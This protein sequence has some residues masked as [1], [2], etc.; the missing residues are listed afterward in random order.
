MKVLKYLALCSEP[1]Q[2]VKVNTAHHLNSFLMNEDFNDFDLVWSYFSSLL[3]LQLACVALDYWAALKH[4][5]KAESFWRDSDCL[6]E[7]VS[8]CKFNCTVKCAFTSLKNQ[9]VWSILR[10]LLEG[11]K[12]I[13]DKPEF[14]KSLSGELILQQQQ[15][16]GSNV[17]QMCLGRWQGKMELRFKIVQLQN[18]QNMA[19]TRSSEISAG[20]QLPRIRMNLFLHSTDFN[21]KRKYRILITVLNSPTLFSVAEGHKALSFHLLAIRWGKKMPTSK[22]DVW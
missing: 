17:D 12:E 5:F 20:Q 7:I 22:F 3:C 9:K 11:K 13:I 6:N 10:C 18:I 14:Y 4:V 15:P 16:S 8:F 19:L 21:F 1:A 2:A